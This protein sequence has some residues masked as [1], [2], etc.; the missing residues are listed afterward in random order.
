MAGKTVGARVLIDR[1]L[2][3]IYPMGQTRLPDPARPPLTTPY[4]GKEASSDR[5]GA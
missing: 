5:A 1:E 3:D 2:R 4:D